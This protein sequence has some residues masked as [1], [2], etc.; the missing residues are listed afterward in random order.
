MCARMCVSCVW[1]ERGGRGRERE[2]EKERERERIDEG[3]GDEYLPAYIRSESSH[4]ITIFFVANFVAFN[5][6]IR[7]CLWQWSC[8]SMYIEYNYSQF[9]SKILLFKNIDSKNAN[10]ANDWNGS[11][12]NRSCW[13][14]VNIL[15]TRYAKLINFQAKRFVSSE[16]SCN[17]P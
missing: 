4:K 11:Q 2:K 16:F 14:N 15:D 17:I 5:V 1:T 3:G 8:I 10:Y 13:R 9:I 12:I 7:T 6:K